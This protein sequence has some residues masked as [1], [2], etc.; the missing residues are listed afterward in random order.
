MSHLEEG[1]SE[2]A[3]ETH[4][5]FLAPGSLPSNFK[6]S[7]A[8]KLAGALVEA[9][10]KEDEEDDEVHFDEDATSD[11]DD[12]G[13]PAHYSHNWTCTCPPRSR[14]LAIA[15]NGHGVS[16][17]ESSSDVAAST[18]LLAYAPLVRCAKC[19][20]QLHSTGSSRRSNPRG[21]YVGNGHRKVGVRSNFQR[22]RR[23]HSYGKATRT[24]GALTRVRSRSRPENTDMHEGSG[25]ACSRKES[26]TGSGIG[27]VQAFMALWQG[28]GS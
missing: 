9:C 5:L 23:N 4:P 2:V 11:V 25:A 12:P 7:T 17:V 21:S 13:K 3:L 15:K 26:R 14:L 20:A 16:N 1:N 10:E 6:N 27:E 19:S 22:V 8:L 18:D 28:I 24:S